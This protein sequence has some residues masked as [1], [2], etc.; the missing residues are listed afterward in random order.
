MTQDIPAIDDEVVESATAEEVDAHLNAIADS[1]QRIAQLR[2]IPDPDA[3]VLAELERNLEHLR[4]MK[5]RVFWADHDVVDADFDVPNRAAAVTAKAARET[6]KADRIRGN[7]N[8]GNSNGNN[9]RK[10]GKR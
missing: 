7:G 8:G 2:A 6:R 4:V 3:D 9:G 1:N 5:A 10:K